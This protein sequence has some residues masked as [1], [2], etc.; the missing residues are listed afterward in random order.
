M[1]M[2]LGM[3]ELPLALF[4]T[5]VPMGAGA[6]L[7]LAAAFFVKRFDAEALKKVDRMTVI[8]IVFVVVGFICAFFHLANPMNA[9]NVF[10]NVGSSPMSNEIVMGLVFCV[11]A[12]VYWIVA[13]AGK[14]ASEGA[15]KGFS[16][17]VAVVGLLFCV[18]VG[19]AY[20]MDT[21][22]SWNN[23]MVPLST[24]FF[25]VLGGSAVG[26]AVFYQAGVYD[27]ADKQLAKVALV[28]SWVGVIGS[29]AFFALNMGTASGLA[30]NMMYGSDVVGAMMPWIV[31]AVIVMVLAGVALMF[32]IQKKRATFYTWIVVVVT[33]VG[34]LLARLSFY[35][36]E[37]S[38]G[39][40]I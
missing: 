13:L 27:A 6:F 36:V 23:A 31:T 9:F 10:A 19:L 8:P 4:S 29:V 20:G 39:L 28:V 35:G 3:T 33:F 37:F 30:N 21:I 16:A 18:F 40:G 34:I 7:M 1:G 14:L 11:V 26:M 12:I 17:V 25:G 22:P 38:A 15:R 32:E 5:L 24:L 2:E